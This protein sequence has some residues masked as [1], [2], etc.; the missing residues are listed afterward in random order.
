M[1]TSDPKKLR[2]YLE[3]RVP[4]DLVDQVIDH[5]ESQDMRLSEAPDQ[6]EGLVSMDV[7]QPSIDPEK[8]VSHTQAFG[9]RSQIARMPTLSHAIGGAFDLILPVSESPGQ[10]GQT[11][12]EAG[13]QIKHFQVGRL[14][15]RGGM[16]EVYL[17]RDTQLGRKVALKVIKPDHVRDQN[18]LERFLQEARLTA[19]FNHPHIVTIYAVGQHEGLP[20][21]ALEYLEGHDLSQRLKDDGL[22]LQESL[23]ICLAVAEAVAEAHKHGILHRDLKPANILIPR[24]GR[25]RVVDFGLAL[26]FVEPVQTEGADRDVAHANKLSG[27]RVAG[28]PAY[29]APEQWRGEECQPETDIWA[30]GVILHELL[31]GERPY[32]AKQSF[33]LGMQVCNADP[34]PLNPIL[35]GL[36]PRISSLIAQ[37]LAKVP[38]ERPSVTTFTECLT[39]V[40]ADGRPMAPV[41]ESPFRGLLPFSERHAN[42]F[43][44]RDTELNTCMERL[45]YESSLVV[46]GPSGAGK[47]SFVQAGLIP[48][49]RENNDW[50]VV[51]MRPGDA[52]ISRLAARLLTAHNEESASHTVGD[53]I[54]DQSLTG[55]TDLTD[56]DSR[57]VE[58]ETLA[59]K[60]RD[61]PN[62][63]GLGLSTLAQQTQQRV[64]LVVDQ[65]EE[66]FTLCQ[67][68]DERIKF[69]E[70]ISNAGDESGDPIRVVCTIRDDF[71]GHLA[72]AGESARRLLEHIMLLDPPDKDA[73]K[74]VLTLP[75]MR[76]G[77]RFDD[78][79]LPDEMVNAVDDAT[80]LPLLQFV[81]RSLW[82]K[83]DQVHHTLRRVDY[84][85]MGGVEGALARHADGVLHGLAQ[86]QM[87]TARSLLLRLVTAEGTRRVCSEAQ[88]LDGLPPGTRVVYERLTK[89]RL[90]SMRR[91]GESDD[92][93]ARLE[94]AHESLIH[95]W[96]KLARWIDESKEELIILAEVTQAA[97]LWEKRGRHQEELWSGAGLDEAMRILGRGQNLLP[98]LTEE[99]L[100][101][102]KAMHE[103][104]RRRRR[105]WTAAIPTIL[106][107]I[108][109]ILALQK[110]DAEESREQSERG[111]QQALHQRKTAE[112]Q[113]R[114]AQSRQVDALRE[115]AQAA[116]ER[117][118]YL[119]SRAKLRKG[120]ELLGADHT[121]F[122]GLWWQLA[123]ISERWS[124]R[125]GQF[126]YHVALSGK[127]QTLAISSVNGS[128]EL[129]DVD[130]GHRR[131]LRG[132][133]DQVLRSTFDPSG[134][135]LASG[136]LGPFVR[137]W[138]VKTARQQNS[139]PAPHGIVRIIRF[140]RDGRYLAVCADRANVRVYD[141]KD[142]S[143][144]DHT[145]PENIKVYDFTGVDQ[146]DFLI[147]GRLDGPLILTKLSDPNSR[148][149][150]GTEL[151]P[152]DIVRFSP[153][154]TALAHRQMSN[155]LNVW[156]VQS[157]Q[158]LARFKANNLRSHSFGFNATASHFAFETP[159]GDIEVVELGKNKRRGRIPNGG[160]QIGFIAVSPDGLHV[161]DTGSD[162]IRYSRAD[163][164]ESPRHDALAVPSLYGLAVDQT[165]ERLAV[166]T[167]N[168]EL[169]LWDGATGRKI[170]SFTQ[171][172]GGKRDS[173]DFSPDGLHLSWLSND[174]DLT[175]W[176]LETNSRMSTFEG[177]RGEPMGLRYDATGQ[178]LVA[179]TDAGV[180]TFNGPKLTL[181]FKRVS[182][183]QLQRTAALS[184]NGTQAV[185]GVGTSDG[186]SGYGE[187]WNL[188]TGWAPKRL[189]KSASF[190]SSVAFD[191]KDQWLATGGFDGRLDLWTKA[192]ISSKTL[193]ADGPRI[194]A[195]DVHPS[196]DRLAIAQ[197]DGQSRIQWVASDR[198]MRLQGHVHEVNH[199]A[200]SGDGRRLA[201]AGDDGT[202]RL[203][204][205]ETGR[206]IWSTTALLPRPARIL[207][208]EGWRSMESSRQADAVLTGA[209]WAKMLE[210][211]GRLASST[212]SGETL[213]VHT[214]DD[215]VE[216][217]NTRSD[218]RVWSGQRTDL[219]TLLAVENGCVVL[220]DDGVL[221]Y[222]P[223]GRAIQFHSE[224][225][226]TAISIFDDGL[227]VA[228][229][230]RIYIY[231]LDYKLRE[232]HLF[233][234]GI[235]AMTLTTA[236]HDG[237]RQLVV[238]FEDGSVETLNI[239]EGSND[240]RSTSV[241]RASA[242]VSRIINIP[243]G[244]L[245][246]GYANGQVIL[247]D[248]ATQKVLSQ[249]QLHGSV[250]YLLAQDNA[251]HAATDLGQSFSWD[252]TA[253][254][255]TRCKLIEDVWSTVPVTWSR[256]Q[257]VASPIPLM[258]SCHDSSD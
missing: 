74:D 85:S 214:H 242:G 239:G 125:T 174:G 139:L 240:M 110:F 13:T 115:S 124:I 144:K 158:R 43:F 212:E 142:K 157:F 172:I 54:N 199:V 234:P 246:I 23:R 134:Q 4:I 11:L 38:D 220:T 16:G 175:V 97:E 201:S 80:S 99:F 117:G 9:D 71:L 180:W 102:G 111:R 232:S 196:G 109:A 32:A 208:H 190:I 59:Q 177:I 227:L 6:E 65:L 193:I 257:P 60:L 12:L 148:R 18:A 30:L 41:E 222:G 28:T 69:I 79:E 243:S 221:R 170:E 49:L 252:L 67:D 236:A 138:N 151:E 135:T 204:D 161:A 202:L 189:M 188:T 75:L 216:L 72:R 120:L 47:T 152:M 187:L 7:D 64:L 90:L 39:T 146:S 77:Y 58:I 149:E 244:L 250:R 130:T 165:G 123:R 251:L 156:H 223:D 197:A 29:M 107:I 171:K 141:L 104:K 241:Y 255:Q 105:F 245:G 36:P 254:G 19:R 128:V 228:S 226:P 112:E 154:G 3:G 198:D 249:V 101:M 88:L 33:N 22:S 258:H 233:S 83:R 167:A 186:S 184:Q 73:L 143:F 116:F 231:G 247:W 237:S 76:V 121:S 2:D 238:G 82:E 70:A 153:D 200:F 206:P 15:G 176:N 50:R 25:V 131:L 118:A 34:V 155:Y 145:L 218:R 256:G 5:L 14:L 52:P 94:L 205:A 27:Q 191:P 136:G 166:T 81:A 78:P 42:L 93:S 31:C 51:R 126:H 168:Q 195:I 48:R 106:M 103:I 203:W 114:Q 127:G 163:L 46:V 133:Q 86:D 35:K 173:I 179:V 219:K 24:D 98:A 20:Y 95:T 229:D 89:S 164:L 8:T 57:Q 91:T 194:N 66:L 160:E 100:E 108:T 183:T 113:R 55:S 122:L 147:A 215:Q 96:D 129:V 132:H 61:S 84:E 181:R 92:G 150:F 53:T 207:T 192:G 182:D 68:Q 56:I 119:E 169:S 87:K 26:E 44:G 137:L 213:C 235:S 248:L 162:Y 211:N 1:D 230:G 225:N 21:V 159:A 209:D 224:Q 217:W 45:R 63:V 178:T 62:K 185:V 253:F 40:L 37:C 140:S 10:K 17:A 210:K